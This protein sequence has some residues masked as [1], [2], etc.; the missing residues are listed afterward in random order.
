MSI[1][2]PATTTVESFDFRRPPWLARERRA[3]LDGAH[4]LIQPG[5]ER[6]LTGALRTPVT[7]TIDDTV[8]LVFGDFR[9]ELR[10]PVVTYIVPLGAGQGGDGLVHLD[11]RFALSLIDIQLGGAGD[12]G[13]RTAPP[14][15]LEQQVLGQMLAAW[16][17]ALQEG[18]ADIAPFTAG[19]LRYEAVA[20]SLETVPRHERVWM[21]RCT[22]VAGEHTGDLS[23]L[24]P[25]ACV[26]GF[27]RGRVGHTGPAPMAPDDLRRLLEQHLRAATIPVAVRLT[28]FRLTARDGA[29]LAPGQVLESNQ[30]FQGTVELHVNGRPR[31]LGA[32]GRHQGH[33]GVRILDRLEGSAIPPRPLRRTSA[34]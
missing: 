23:L 6:V 11:P 13:T 31:F 15:P 20:E 27:A 29:S 32:L 4:A 2:D 34:T 1:V 24:L 14:T 7:V 17:A 16:V 21:I 22:I 10:S 19:P 33:V 26:E 12:V 3:V 25:A 9:R 5:I 28:G 8:Q 18:Y 30:A